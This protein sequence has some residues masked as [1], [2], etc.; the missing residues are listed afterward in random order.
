ML[1]FSTDDIAPQDR[2]EHWREV[3]GKSLFGATI[4]LPREQRAGFRARFEAIEVGGALVSMVTGSPYTMSRTKA[5]IARMAGNSLNLN[6]QVRG[7]GVLDVGNEH[8]QRL[9]DGEIA[10]THSDVPFR[11]IPTRGGSFDYQILRIPLRGDVVLDANVENLMAITSSQLTQF[12]RPISALFNA[13]TNP[14]RRPADPAAAVTHIARLF[15]LERGRLKLG[16]SETRAALRAGLYHAACEIL[17]RDL[18]RHDLSPNHVASELGISLR[19]LH[20][21]FEPSG[22]SFSRTLADIRLEHAFRL[23]ETQ[24]AL[25]II[26][27]AEASGIESQ[28]TFYR[29]FRRAFDMT[30]G[31]K[32]WLA[33]HK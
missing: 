2:F 21:L 26:D 27:V 5:D 11:A 23:F 17:A 33:R 6:R 30:P 12:S 32:Q 19:Q 20:L 15:M 22:R 14:S 24:P 1:S 7:L 10:F 8:A 28:A 18:S 3:R 4:E 29:G 16:L 9:G 13:V 25:S 31:D